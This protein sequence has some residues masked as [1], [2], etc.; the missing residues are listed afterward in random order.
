MPNKRN[1]RKNNITAIILTCALGFLVIFL[2]AITHRPLISYIVQMI[3]HDVKPICN[4]CNVIVVSVDTLSALHLPCYGYS[5][6]TSPHLCTFAR[7][8][9]WFTN[10][11]AQSFFTLPSHFSIFTSLYPSTHGVLTTL[12][13]SL[14]LNHTTL[15]QIL[16]SKGYNTLYF[17][18]INN[19]MLPLDKG[20]G[21]GF[22]YINPTYTYDRGELQN[23]YKG[24]D[25]LKANQR[26][27]KP[28]FLFLHTYAVHE[29][30]LPKTTALHF[31]TDRIPDLPLTEEAFYKLT[32]E[33]VV[34]LQNYF[35]QNPIERVVDPAVRSTYERFL[36]AGNSAN[37]IRLYT[38]LLNTGI[39]DFGWPLSEYYYMN[40][41]NNPQ[42]VAYMKALFDELILQL[43]GELPTFF[44]RL[45]P[46]LQTNTILIITAD[47]GEGFMEHGE[48]LHT[49]LYN[50]V[51]RVPLIMS[52]PQVA[53]VTVR[54]PVEGIDIYPTVLRLLGIHPESEIEGTDMTGSILG[55]PLGVGKPFI[56]SE[57][58]RMVPS[59]MHKDV[60]LKQKTILNTRWKLYLK[61]IDHPSDPK[62]LELYAVTDLWDSNNVA[63]Q[64]PTVVHK[65]LTT[66]QQFSTNHPV[67]YPSPSEKTPGLI[68]EELLKQQYYRY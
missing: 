34:Y 1:G 26:Q 33:L 27:G 15:T 2:Y 18:P 35:R 52:I 40:N 23:W 21:R 66:L 20:I 31:T 41:G 10:S 59:A 44:D 54:T 22:D 49:T 29:P 50:E 39:S 4:H 64:Y 55:L 7:D 57:L 5:R 63:D 56:I 19:E 28:T 32:P 9:I 36:N 13:D 6:N 53:P 8:H 47:H 38:E 60:P 68:Q 17:G 3:H 51:L 45:K 25:M 65:M 11:Y 58:Y 37:T 14:G 67:T 62:K 30:F 48:L 24:I 43:D 12:T 61:D 16:Q 42:K 46:L